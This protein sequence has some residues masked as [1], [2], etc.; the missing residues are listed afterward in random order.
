MTNRLALL[1]FVFV[2]VASA[3]GAELTATVARNP[4][5]VGETTVVRLSGGQLDVAGGNSFDSIGSEFAQAVEIQ[6]IDRN[7]FQ[8]KGLAACECVL[9]FGDGKNET[10]VKLR[11]V[12][13]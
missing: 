12:K 6:K 10:T 13:K 9:K 8:V 5:N 7:R 1:L 11:V 3:Q 4:I 2:L